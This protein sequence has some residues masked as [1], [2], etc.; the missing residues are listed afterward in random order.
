M[1]KIE[2]SLKNNIKNDFFKGKVIIV[3]GARQVGK[4]TLI[5]EF[6]EEFPNS[7]YFNCDEP[8]TKLLFENKT[9]T[10]LLKLFGSAKVVFIDEAQR[11]LNIGLTL[12]LIVD[13]DPNIQIIATGSSSFDLANKINEPLTGRNFKYELFPFSSTELM[14]KYDKFE[15][16]RLTEQRIIYGS[17]PQPFFLDKAERER[18]LLELASDYVFKDILSFG[19]IRKSDKIVN[20]L[21]AL[22]LQIGSEVSYTEL[23]QLIGLNHNTIESYI[24]L[25]EQSFIIF[26]LNPYMMNQRNSIRKSRKIYFFDTGLRNALINN[27]N[28][29]NLRNDGGALF[30]N[31]FIAEKLKECFNAGQNINSYFW[32]DYQKREIDLILEKAGQIEAFECKLN[33]KKNIKKIGD[34]EAKIMTQENYLDFLI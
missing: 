16:Q 29:L 12:K 11:V 28:P 6:K 3:Y 7:L 25:L 30:E 24:T 33:D 19:G 1:Y 4:T 17:Y 8:D 20:L 5:K 10:E 2:R 18:R 34:I 9:S 27:F 23:S 22:A 15:L 13:N 31:F 26:R 32:R 21:K 14:K